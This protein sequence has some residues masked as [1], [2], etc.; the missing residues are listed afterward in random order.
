MGKL[1][2]TV[3]SSRKSTTSEKA[4]IIHISLKGKELGSN[5]FVGIIRVISL[6]TSVW[7]STTALWIGMAIPHLCG[8]MA[9]GMISTMQKHWRKFASLQTLISASVSI[10]SWMKAL[11][12]T[13]KTVIRQ[14][15]RYSMKT[16]GHYYRSRKEYEQRTGKSSKYIQN[17]PC[18][19]AYSSY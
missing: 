8:I 17:N 3:L 16:T 19:N 9:K 12:H 4:E 2:D 18:I 6:C 10:C 14:T 11:P 5:S 1:I 7:N 13:P 15:E